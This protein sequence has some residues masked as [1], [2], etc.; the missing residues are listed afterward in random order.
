M[1]SPPIYFPPAGGGAPPQPTH[2]MAPGGPPLGF[3]GGAPIPT[4][5]PPIYYPPAGG[6]APPVPTHPIYNPPGIWGGGNVPFPTPPI[7]QPPPA[8]PVLDPDSLPDHP[9]VPDLNAGSWVYVS[10]G[11]MLV[12]AFVPWPLAV[13]HP[14]YNP[15]YP[16]DENQPGEWVAI[17]FMDANYNGLTWAWIPSVPEVTHHPA[18]AE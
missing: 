14:D 2:P 9:E 11:N 17:Y 3:W 6:G 13:T 8:W 5:T 4:P 18:P 12:Q 16:P 7:Y 1:P 10:Q 15:N